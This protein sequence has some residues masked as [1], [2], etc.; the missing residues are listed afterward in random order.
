M[1]DQLARDVGARVRFHRLAAKKTQAVIAGLA[2]ITVDYLYQIERGK[3]AP[4]L[5]VLVGLAHALDI[6]VGALVEEVPAKPP[7]RSPDAASEAL[8]RAMTLPAP[9]ADRGLAVGE[10]RQRVVEAW[11]LWQSSPTRYSTV[12]TLVSDLIVDVERC[13]HH[14]GSRERMRMAADLY[15]LART[16]AKRTGR[17]DLAFVAADRAR[18][19][20]EAS[21]DRLRVG[22][23]QWNLAHATL[24]EGDHGLAE[25]LAMRA[26]DRVRT[27]S[28]AD[29]AAVYGSLVLVA[30]VAAARRGDAWTARDRIR[31]V[32][33]VA[34]KTGE[35]NTLWTCFGPTNVAMH[36]VSVEVE[37]GEVSEACHLADGVDPRT[38][39]R[40][41]GGWR[42]GSNK[43]APTS[44]AATTAAPWYCCATRRAKRR[45]TWP[46]AR[47]R[48]PSCA[49]WCSTPDAPRR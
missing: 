14:P 5:S 4:T 46:T 13:L 22:A 9:D 47:W 6:P 37:A 21:E 35:R 43:P 15:G 42:S 7:V 20:A 30:A 2:G 18:R 25:D 45:R 29:A 36:A 12:P 24:A 44:S 27:D 23:A 3:K 16:V 1:T 10:L 48:A 26:A 19:A 28:G 49:P 41:S 31:S 33:P 8:Y 39:R 34:L 32:M 40:S 17:V 11:R 38:S